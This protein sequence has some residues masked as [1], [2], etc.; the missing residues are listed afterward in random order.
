MLN[1]TLKSIA[2]VLISLAVLAANMP[3]VVAAG[4]TESAS[5]QTEP[6]VTEPIFTE[7]VVTEPAV[8]EPAIT[9]LIPEE[10]AI[11][12]D[13]TADNNS[14]L[15]SD[16]AASDP[17]VTEP[18]ATDPS[19]ADPAV[20]DTALTGEE[21][22]LPLTNDDVVRP[23]FAVQWDTLPMYMGS[24]GVFRW[25]IVYENGGYYIHA[26]TNMYES[27]SFSI[28]YEEY[29]EELLRYEASTEPVILNSVW[30]PIPG[31]Y[32]Q[33]YVENNTRYSEIY[34]PQSFFK[35][36]MFTITCGQAVSSLDI[37]DSFGMPAMPDIWNEVTTLEEPVLG[38]SDDI[39]FI[40]QVNSIVA[41]PD[42]DN[43]SWGMT[44][45][46]GNYCLYI[47]GNI[48]NCQ[49]QF[50]LCDG[51]G[52]YKDHIGVAATPYYVNFNYN[53]INVPVANMV[54]GENNS[55][56]VKFVIPDGVFPDDFQIDP[57]NGMP[58]ITSQ[59]IK[60]S[61][62]VVPDEPED[63]TVAA[64][65]SK[66][67][68]ESWAIELGSDGLYH[69][70]IVDAFNE[71]PAVTVTDK[72][73][74]EISNPAP[75]QIASA[76]KDGLRYSE[77]TLSELPQWFD[78][79]C[80]GE[81]K[82]F[83]TNPDQA[84]IEGVN[85]NAN[86]GWNAVLNN[87]G[88]C[89]IYVVS[90]AEPSAV[91][92][93][94]E[95]HVSADSVISIDEALT[96]TVFDPEAG[97]YYTQFT[98]SNASEWF[99]VTYNG[100][101]MT[102]GDN[103]DQDIID[104]ISN[105]VGSDSWKVEK[106]EDG[107]YHIYIVDGAYDYANITATDKASGSFLDLS[108]ME[109]VNT[110]E[111]NGRRYT[112]Y[113]VA[114]DSE[115]F[116][117]A[118]NGSLP[119]TFGKDPNAAYTGIVIDGG[120]ADWDAVPKY[121]ANDPTGNVQNVAIVWAGEWIYLYIEVGANPAAINW[122]GNN[123]TGNFVIVT[124]LGKELLLKPRYDVNND[125][126]VV[127]GID[128]AK[129]E[130]DCAELGWGSSNYHYEIAV[131]SGLLPEYMESISFGHYLVD[132]YVKGVT[133]MLG[134]GVDPDKQFN[135]IVFDGE[136]LDWKYYPHTVIQYAGGG[137][138]EHVE[139]AS[140][141]LYNNGDGYV[142]GHTV[143]TMQAHQNQALGG[144]WQFYMSVNDTN[145]VDLTTTLM[146]A[147]PDGKLHFA[148]EADY[149]QNMA[150]VGSAHKYYIVD[151]SYTGPKENITLDEL[152]ATGQFYGEAYVTKSPSQWDIEYKVDV[153]MLAKK[154]GLNNASDVKTINAQF[155]QLG[156]K[157][158][159]AGGTSTGALLG[160][161]LCLATVSGTYFFKKKK[162]MGIK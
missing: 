140:G 147:G 107:R 22:D 160:I 161:F 118:Y 106:G 6:A 137:T 92:F 135:G 113:A 36:V 155:H 79:T 99:N 34:I 39:A 162:A 110:A 50:N 29:G 44:Y 133:D 119:V 85:A 67:G 8:T 78:I 158:V 143:T 125:I 122:S 128:G 23:I 102:L 17:L 124:D 51:D 82:T 77:Y 74:N 129:M 70:Y 130:C 112:E 30:N 90:N 101:S 84:F 48:N 4:I 96:K 10:T 150:D 33:S 40:E 66:V 100:V 105:K 60:G 98:V 72:T 159:T 148:T 57:Q 59:Q 56:Y 134:S 104:K 15:P 142:Y 25:N 24:D 2:A 71:A 138:H 136:Y 21:S 131:P 75:Y 7:P 52:N 42:S 117:I 16:P 86:G 154:A 115:W 27:T 11:P 3:T 69:L 114:I 103:P 18:S 97:K 149:A 111:D 80:N 83:G 120:F 9:E 109:V 94:F 146:C 126:S 68:S 28:L 89:S 53:G 93:M 123:S 62:S 151:T 76:E 152:I 5:E 13:N 12:M 73:S 127:D 116:D 32:V 63:P 49:A 81:T 1:K 64:V 14:G 20:A 45:E 121:P 145:H 141:A 37:T 153:E 19:A 26:V 61:G 46:N 88:T 58:R 43:G 65:Q 91:D 139:D 157:W 87:D 156:Y 31:A 95:N 108:L 54:N 41:D 144:M 132:P 47:K 38:A 35:D 55:L